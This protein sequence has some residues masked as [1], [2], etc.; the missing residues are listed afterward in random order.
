MGR[1]STLEPSYEI[2]AYVTLHKERVLAGKALSL[3]AADE[4]EAK[5]L[6]LDIAKAMKADVVQL[7][8]GDYMVLR[9]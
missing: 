3:W 8:S 7:K 9:V 5:L 2:L 1:E 4:E 6:T